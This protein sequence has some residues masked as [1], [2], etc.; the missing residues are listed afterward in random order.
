MIVQVQLHYW[1]AALL[2]L[3]LAGAGIAV[4]CFC[5]WLDFRH[6][7]QDGRDD[8][9][10]DMDRPVYVPDP[11][12]SAPK[13]LIDEQAWDHLEVWQPHPWQDQMADELAPAALDAAQP[14]PAGTGVDLIPAVVPDETAGTLIE[15]AR[16]LLP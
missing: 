1:Q 11:P 15:R 9:R 6:D 13:A 12:P 7:Y 16:T 2:V 10:D 5:T 14:P 3:G 4:G 8:Q